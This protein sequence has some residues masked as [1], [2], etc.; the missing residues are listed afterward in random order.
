M[1]TPYM[2]L[3]LSTTLVVICDP[4]ETVGLYCDIKVALLYFKCLCGLVFKKKL[5]SDVSFATSY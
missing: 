5:R 4:F 1:C 3:I 2:K